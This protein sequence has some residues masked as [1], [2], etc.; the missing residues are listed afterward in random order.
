MLY[1][2]IFPYF[3]YNLEW[4]IPM[5]LPSLHCPP[6]GRRR[7]PRDVTLRLP[8]RFTLHPTHRS[9]RWKLPLHWPTQ[10]CLCTTKFVTLRLHRSFQARLAARRRVLNL[11]RTRFHAL[12]LCFLSSTVCAQHGEKRKWNSVQK[13]TEDSSDF[14]IITPQLSKS[15]HVINHDKITRTIKSDRQRRKRNAAVFTLHPLLSARNLTN[16]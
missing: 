3:L 13:H 16:Q 11:G 7:Q 5:I 15:I 1:F 10:G 9:G 8:A 12:A 6:K 2:W 14:L 4:P